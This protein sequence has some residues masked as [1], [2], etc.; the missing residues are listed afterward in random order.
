[1]YQQSDWLMCYPFMATYGKNLL[2]I[3]NPIAGGKNKDTILNRLQFFCKENNSICNFY[4]TKGKE[5][6]GYIASLFKKLKPDAV[7]AV[8]GDGTV[9]LAGN[10]LVE[11]DTPLGIIPA[12]SANGLA[13]DVG[14]SSNKIDDALDNIKKFNIKNIDTLHVNHINSFHLIDIGFNARVCH[15]FAESTIR[16][17][18]SYAFIALKEFIKFKSFPYRIE[19]A[20]QTYEGLAYMVT[21]TN[22]NKIGTN[23][24]INPLGKIDDGF[25]EINIIK[26]FPRLQILKIIY[27]LLHG[28]IHKSPYYE[29]IRCQEAIVTNFNNESLHI[30]GEPKEIGKRMKVKIVRKGLKVLL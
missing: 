20:M 11:T 7:V 12:G 16:G 18:L 28:S 26:P 1:V 25:F 8:G 23:M 17:K 19:T 22:S 13:K 14:I 27:Q 5:D 10:I 15:S 24:E 30:D 4:K 6:H 3:V 9:N 21:L 2:F 29:S